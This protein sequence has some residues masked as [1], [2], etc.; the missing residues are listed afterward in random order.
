MLLSHRPAHGLQIAEIA[1]GADG[2]VEL[3]A[4]FMDTF[5]E[6]G[7][8]YVRAWSY[9]LEDGRLRILP[10]PEY[11]YYGNACSPEEMADEQARL[12]KAGVGAET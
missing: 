11:P 10:P 4:Y 3:R 7:Q 1:P 9:A 2:A 12:D 5:P 6:D 8:E